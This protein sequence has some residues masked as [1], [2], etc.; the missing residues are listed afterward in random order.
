MVRPKKVAGELQTE[1]IVVYVTPQT[2]ENFRTAVERLVSSESKIGD[3]AI[4]SWLRAQGGNYSMNQYGQSKGGADLTGSL[5]GAEVI[6]EQL[7]TG[8]V[9]SV[10]K[11]LKKLKEM[12]FSLTSLCSSI[13][14]DEEDWDRQYDKNNP[15]SMYTR[16]SLNNIE[17]KLTEALD[18]LQSLTAP[19]ID[20]GTL[21]KNIGGRYELNGWEYTSGSSID[22][23]HSDSFDELTRW[24]NSR[25]EFH[26]GDYF[27]VG[28]PDVKLDGLLVRR[29]A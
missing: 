23:L 4:Q 29:K 28:Y 21:V 24:L 9:S 15:D 7:S 6:H 12:S 26:N 18:I 13:C 20:Q 2:K 27:I 22:F 14:R 3:I 19:I 17:E 1:R 8:E 10:N 5:R 25:V 16:D 11:N